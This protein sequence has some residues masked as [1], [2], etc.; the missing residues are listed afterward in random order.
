MRKRMYITANMLRNFETSALY[1]TDS[2]GNGGTRR[3]WIRI[4]SGALT[5]AVTLSGSEDFE[6]TSLEEAVRAFNE[7][8]GA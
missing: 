5:Y 6:T 8:G 4:K 7:A 1:A 3:L 2:S